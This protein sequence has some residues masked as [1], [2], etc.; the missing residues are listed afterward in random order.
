MELVLLWSRAFPLLLGARHEGSSYGVPAHV[1][2]PL[3]MPLLPGRDAFARAPE[4]PLP[5]FHIL[6]IDNEQLGTRAP[7]SQ[8]NQISCA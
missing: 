4:K 1:T 6:P 3:F 5:P 8:L 2:P 7:C